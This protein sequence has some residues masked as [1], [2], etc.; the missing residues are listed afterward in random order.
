MSQKK[1]FDKRLKSNSDIRYEVENDEVVI[2]WY[3]MGR[4]KDVVA[5]SL[6]EAI[7]S[8]S[9]L[10]QAVEVARENRSKK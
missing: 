5:F 1:E 9:V 3:D 4:T 6:E 8:I 7:E 2:T 10:Q